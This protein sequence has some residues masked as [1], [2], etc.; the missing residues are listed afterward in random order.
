LL[1]FYDVFVTFKLPQNTGDRAFSQ[2]VVPLGGY[3]IHSH[4]VQLILPE[5][6]CYNEVWKDIRAVS[7]GGKRPHRMDSKRNPVQSA[8]EIHQ[9]G[10]GG[11]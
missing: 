4:V 2:L 7:E 8:E 5:V 11:D 9:T 10:R 1:F 3:F 6:Y